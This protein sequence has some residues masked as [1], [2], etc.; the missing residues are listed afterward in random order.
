MN[1][2][3][4]KEIVSEKLGVSLATINNWI[5]TKVIPSPDIQNN[6]SQTA[7][8]N[9][10]EIIQN[11]QYRL[12]SRA[13]RTLQ[14]KKTIC[15]LGI[16]DKNRKQLLYNLVNDFEQSNLSVDDGVLSVAFSM[17]LS[18][19]IIDGNWQCNKDSMFDIFL[20]DW[21]DKSSNPTKIKTFF[22]NYKIKNLDD[23]ILGAFYQSIQSISQK[24]NLGSYYTPSGLL[25]GI[26]IPKDKTILDP[27]C[28]SGSIL[29]NIIKKEHDPSKIFA[30]DIDELAIKIC[31][32]NLVL[33]FNNKNIEPNISKQ[34]LTENNNTDLF[35]KQNNNNFDYIVTNPPWG[36]KFSI[37]Q[38]ENFYKLYPELATSETFSICLYNATKMLNKN[39]ELYFFLPHSFLNVS[40]HKNIRQYIFNEN[41][42]ISIK[43]LGNAF[44]GVVS[45]SIL[46]HLKNNSSNKNILIQNKNAN[47]YEIAIQ[48][49]GSPDYIVSANSKTKDSMI[50]NKIYN[51]E[52]ITLKNNTV[53][54]LGIVTGN[55]KK[56][57]LEKKTKNTEPIFRGKDINKYVFL[58]PKYYLEF[59]PD[60]YQQVASE[61]Y[62]RK[63]KIVY[64]F[65]SDKIICALDKENFLLLNSANLFITND[66]PMETIVAFFNSDIYTFIY[67]KLFHSKKLLKSHLQTLPLPVLSIDDHKHIYNLYNETF[68]NKDK[69][70]SLFQYQIDKIIC[71]TFLI[72]K[73]EFEYIK[74]EVNGNS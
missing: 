33:F 74:V 69:N 31:F 4:P 7:F 72:S 65:I 19:K 50:I 1:V 21:I 34:D 20:S 48:S 46:L 57:L 30:R 49:I 39:G 44:K 40:T 2:F 17:L 28:G 5:K 26:K 9:I 43:L 27:C 11:N 32:I 29:L 67:R 68:S 18:N 38:K 3:I 6:Y 64:R 70:I 71:D 60:L 73:K 59:K 22:S 56:H 14:N 25:N 47:M 13:N 12:N 36:S 66:Y 53:F 51:A 37:R 52:H 42:E 8:E 24:S 62:Y 55:N 15:Y 45:E 54:V 61:K 23:D 35:L 58:E 63:E 41:N 10:V 16:E